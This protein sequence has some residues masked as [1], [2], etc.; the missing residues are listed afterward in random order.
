MRRLPLVQLLTLRLAL[1]PGIFYRLHKAGYQKGPILHPFQFRRKTGTALIHFPLACFPSY[2]HLIFL[3]IGPHLRL[4]P[5]HTLVDSGGFTPCFICPLKGFW[6][7]FS[8]AEHTV[9]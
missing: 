3:V 8:T 1:V 7:H 2:S 9:L 6:S 5:G 4:T